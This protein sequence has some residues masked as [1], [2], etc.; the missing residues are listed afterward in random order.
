MVLNALVDGTSADPTMRPSSSPPPLGLDRYPHCLRQWRQSYGLRLADLA[1]E[2]R[3]RGYDITPNYLGRI[4]TGSREY[5]QS[6][7]VACADIYG[8]TP[9]DLLSRAPRDPVE[10]FQSLV[11]TADRILRLSRDPAVVNR[12]KPVAM[13]E[14]SGRRIRI[15]EA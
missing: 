2:L 3:Q 1:A 10:V 11:Q 15:K 14:K 4:E 8:C 5:R 7:L 13:T 9:A 12:V 6:L